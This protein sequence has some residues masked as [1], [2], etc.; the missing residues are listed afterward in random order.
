M[1]NFPRILLIDDDSFWLESL[2]EYLRRKGF[3]VLEAR[4]ADE[5]LALLEKEEVSLIISD[6]KLPGMDGLHLVR[7]LRHQQRRV[8]IVMLSSEDEATLADRAVS[9]GAHAFFAKAAAPSQLLRKIRQIISAALVKELTAP[10]LHLWQRLLPNPN[11]SGYNNSKERSI[12]SLLNG[13]SKKS[14]KP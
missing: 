7:H 12:N 9:A 13:S 2:A 5:A 1:S 6:Y 4:S 3:A 14:R 10:A 11:R 8:A